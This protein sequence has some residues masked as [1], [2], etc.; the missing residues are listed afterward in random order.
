ME[1]MTLTQEQVNL[2][3]GIMVE[4]GFEEL[5]EGSNLAEFTNNLYSNFIQSAPLIVS[6]LSRTNFSDEAE[7]ST[8]KEFCR[9]LGDVI[10][11]LYD[12]QASSEQMALIDVFLNQLATTRK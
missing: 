5:T 6:L 8:V 3:R 4:T 10:R 12:L 7:Q 11:T 2:I 9:G 1:T